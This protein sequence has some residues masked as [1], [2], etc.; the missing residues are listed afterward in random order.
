[1]KA[2]EICHIASLEKT[3]IND[4]LVIDFFL[5]EQETT[6]KLQDTILNEKQNFR[7]KL[8]EDAE[9]A[10]LEQQIFNFPKS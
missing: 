1:M 7:D 4:K 8:R 10:Q 3:N 5:A 9:I 6:K 2:R